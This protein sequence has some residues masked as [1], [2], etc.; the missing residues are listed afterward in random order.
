MINGWWKEKQEPH[1]AL[2]DALA[3]LQEQQETRESRYR[4]FLSFYTGR[5]VTD[6]YDPPDANLMPI[7][8]DESRSI[9][10]NVIQSIVDTFVSRI[11]TGNPMPR[12]LTSGGEW[13][14]RIKS[15]HLEQF[16]RGV[17][18]DCG[19]YSEAR[20]M[21][22]DA[23][24]FGDGFLKVAQHDGRVSVER[25]F[26]AE[27]IVDVEA[28]MR[29]PPRCLY[30]KYR[31]SPEV[32]VALYPKQEKKIIASVTEERKVSGIGTLTL[33]ESVE[34]VEA[35]HLP[36]SSKADDGRH[37]IAVEHATL[38]DEQ[39][40]RKTFPFVHMQFTDCQLGYFG[41]GVPE[42]RLDMQREI[43][44][45][46]QRIQ[47][48][49][50]FYAKVDTY[51]EEGSIDPKHLNN[52]SG[53]VIFYRKGSPPPV[54][55]A[56]GSMPADA[57]TYLNDLINK[58][59]ELEGVSQL[60]A[61]SKKPAGIDSGVAIM[62]LSDLETVR[63]GEVMDAYQQCFKRLA[64][65]V[66][67]CASQIYQSSDD[68]E[69][70]YRAK[71]FVKRIKWKDVDMERDKYVIHVYPANLLP[72]TPAGR[73]QTVEQMMGSGLFDKEEARQLLDMPDVQAQMSLSN[74]SVEDIDFICEQM[75]VEGKYLPPEPYQNLQL[76]VSRVMSR[77]LEAR[78]FGAPDSRLELL[79]RWIDDALYL[80]EPPPPPP[81]AMPPPPGTMP[82]PPPPEAGLPPEAAMMEPPPDLPPQA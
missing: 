56:Q 25:V 49:M 58:A 1:R 51:A 7:F 32:L 44:K 2:F 72:H 22:K 23:C 59:Y 73:L 67:Y 29:T 34:V 54:P 5:Q 55:R 8:A 71:D 81:G 40:D 3:L 60:S 16:L 76:G 21:F 80:L 11:A 57:F 46:A 18:D 61:Q 74:S 28:S 48:A 17:F 70:H 30:Q 64:E 65:E 6:L 33:Q 35:W 36:S 13:S 39:W 53:N 43:N 19:A 24:I 31:V 45:M 15:R 9:A 26:P 41:Q 42:R 20:R 82:P 10:I 68:F 14:D 47:E 75:L 66:I 27:I 62:N 78:R 79:Q 63:H 50:H 52:S 4:M 37:L 38:F 69:V 12:V 77:W